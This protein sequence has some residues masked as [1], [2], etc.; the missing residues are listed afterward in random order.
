M[1]PLGEPLHAP[2]PLRVEETPIT[3]E[4][5]VTILADCFVAASE[6]GCV[7]S[8]AQGGSMES[9]WKSTVPYGLVSWG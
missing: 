2:P 4:D 8:R 3:V 1:S 6:N 7:V 9:P 5:D